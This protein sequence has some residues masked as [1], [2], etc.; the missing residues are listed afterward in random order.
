MQVK[1]I[2]KCSRGSIL[3][4]FRPSLS[5]HLSLTSLFRL[6]LSGRLRQVLLSFAKIYSQSESY[7]G[8]SSH[9]IS[10]FIAI[11]KTPSDVAWSFLYTLYY[12]RKISWSLMFPSSQ[13]SLPKTMSA[14]TLCETFDSLH[15][16]NSIFPPMKNT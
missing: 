5:Y 4:Y 14:F 16:L 12:L 7:S 13:V 8:T 10:S 2:A 15:C 11:K 9:L 1:S 3:Q 6:F